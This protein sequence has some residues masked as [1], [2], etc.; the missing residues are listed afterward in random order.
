MKTRSLKYPKR[1]PA[2]PA[3]AAVAIA[4]LAVLAGPSTAATFITA[5][6]TVAGGNP[7]NGNYSGQ[8]VFVGVDGAFNRVANVQVDVI[9]PAQLNYSDQTGGG[10]AAYSNSVVNVRGGSFGQYSPTGCCGGISANDTSRLNISGG[11][12]DGLSVNGAAAGAAGARADVSGGL[13]QNYR[14]S[15]A[16]VANGVLNVSGGTISSSGGQPA[17]VGNDGGVINISGGL[18][19]SVSGAAVISSAGSALS[20]SGG[21]VSGLASRAFGIVLDDAG[22]TA[23]L[24]GGT[25]NGG[26]RAD[27]YSA[28]SPALQATLSG[29]LTLNG[30]AFALRDA[31]LDITGGSY[32]A[33]AGS[34][35]HFFALG[36]N[37]LNFYGNGL[38]LSGPTAG[39]VFMDYSY[40]GNFYT[41]TSGTFSGGQSAVGLRVFDALSFYGS[42]VGMGGGVTLTAA[43][44]E[45][46]EWA[47]LLAGLGVLS[48]FAS[49]RQRTG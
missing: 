39:S 49:R 1:R 36:S 42:S 22:S 43:V 28:A 9:D 25:I 40:D 24:R 14:R 29:S 38:E 30:G 37:N 48:L 6:R 46:G 7:I 47:M 11:T 16:I 13:I 27:H 19:Q 4:A 5:D 23:D 35:A 33:Y 10:L 32:T 26:L 21:T 8:G 3:W 44:P 18:V 41:F 15:V 45:P 17:L 20:M 31:A 34:V 12:I 2:A